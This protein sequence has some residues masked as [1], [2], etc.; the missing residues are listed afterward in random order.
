[1]IL[2][3]LLVAADTVT[4]TG[5]LSMTFTVNVYAVHGS[6]LVA[7]YRVLVAFIWNC[8]SFDHTSI[9]Y[10]SD[11]FNA[12]PKGGS[13]DRDIHS[14]PISFTVNLSTEF[15]S[16][17]KDEFFEASNK[18]CFVREKLNISFEP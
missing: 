17:N 18:T 11:S 10:V 5:S 13:Q 4:P 16:V 9:K 12:V 2:L 14:M 15:R 6:S 3:L 1:M 8:L 7:L